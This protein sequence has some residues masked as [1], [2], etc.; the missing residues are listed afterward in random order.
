[1]KHPSSYLKLRVL[2]AIDYAE[3]K[4]LRQR[5]KAVA[6][7]EYMDEEGILRRF[8]WRTISTWLY[9]YK[10]KGVTGLDVKV[11]KDKGGVRKLTPEELLEAINAVIPSFH[12][13]NYTKMDLYR[14]CIQK[15]FLTRDQISQTN[16][17]RYVREYD[18]LSEDITKVSKRRQ[19]FSMQYANDLWCLRG[20]FMIPQRLAIYIDIR[21]HACYSNKFHVYI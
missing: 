17:Y 1:M 21:I 13:K 5:I 15:G 14:S 19:A 2:T 3:G 9:R 4:T 18:L 20:T 6:N 12:N 11:R 10:S 16:F 8:T 7:C